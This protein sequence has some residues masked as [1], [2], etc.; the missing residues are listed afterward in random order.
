[1][2]YVNKKLLAKLKAVTLYSTSDI[3]RFSKSELKKVSHLFDDGNKKY[4]KVLEFLNN[5]G[6][7]TLSGCV[8]HEKDSISSI[9]FQ[10]N[11]ENLEKVLTISNNLIETENMSIYMSSSMF[12]NP[13]NMVYHFSINDRNRVYNKIMKN[14]N[15]KKSPNPLLSKQ[16]YILKMISQRT[17]FLNTMFKLD[18]FGDRKRLNVSKKYEFSIRNYLDYEKDMYNAKLIYNI[19][20]N[21]NNLTEIYNEI[22]KIPMLGGKKIY[23]YDFYGSNV[24]ELKDLLKRVENSHEDTNIKETNDLFIKDLYLKY[25]N[26]CNFLNIPINSKEFFYVLREVEEHLKQIIA[27][28]EYKNS[29]RY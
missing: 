28:I 23:L 10:L 11:D 17:S 29:K 5:N 16:Y 18:L 21:T 19:L 2:I 14:D 8:G 1:M 26:Y 22:R 20:S 6:I 24:D 7:C 13:A 15:K 12:N 9:A 27:K 25:E 3:H 4:R